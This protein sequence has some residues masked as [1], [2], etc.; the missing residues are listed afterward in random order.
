MEVDQ[1]VINRAKRAEGQLAGVIR[2]MEDERECM[3][4]VTQLS[5]VRSSID[6]IIGI[7]VAENL[8]ECINNPDEDSEVQQ[9]KIEKAM[10][11][12]MKK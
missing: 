7:V 5:A 9:A 11:L 1:K 12:I 2:M 6:R 3:D 10:Q 4:V 8:Y